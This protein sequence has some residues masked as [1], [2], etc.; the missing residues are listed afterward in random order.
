M[1]VLKTSLAILAAAV[2][3]QMSAVGVAAQEMSQ[4]QELNQ[5]VSVDCEAG[6]YG[7]SSCHVDATQSGK[8]SQRIVYRQDG[9]KVVVHQPVNTALDAKTMALIGSFMVL[10]IGSAVIGFRKRAA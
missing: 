2:A 6:A 5:S 10:G 4:E 3:L 7:Q 1:R 9:S 8:Q